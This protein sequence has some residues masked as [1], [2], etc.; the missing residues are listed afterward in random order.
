MS[1]IQY[2]IYYHYIY[3]FYIFSI[4]IHLDLILNYNRDY[5]KQIF[6]RI[7]IIAFFY[8]ENY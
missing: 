5:S 6:V 7:L 2:K 4:T 3:L 1:G 8:L